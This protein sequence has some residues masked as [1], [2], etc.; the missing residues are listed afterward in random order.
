MADAN[1]APLGT[2]INST[3]L[4]TTVVVA[5][6][7]PA[8]NFYN[9]YTGTNWAATV[10]IAN[11]L[12]S[13][14]ATPKGVFCECSTELV[15]FITPYLGPLKQVAIGILVFFFLVFIAC[16]YLCCSGAGAEPKKDE[17]TEMRSVETYEGADLARP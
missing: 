10:P 16:I 15:T 14:I 17:G 2:A 11:G 13:V 12:S 1:F 7:S 5:T 4:G 3:C 9:C 6:A 8:S